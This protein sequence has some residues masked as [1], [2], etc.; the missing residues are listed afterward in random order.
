MDGVEKERLTEKQA[1]MRRVN[2]QISRISQRGRVE[3]EI[4]ELACECAHSCASQ[5]ELAPAEYES[6]RKDPLLFLLAHGHEVPDVDEVVTRA[7]GYVL[8]RKTDGRPAA[9]AKETDTPS[10]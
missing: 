6:A 3:G 10:A 2:E 7:A 1:R 5:V 4:V 8:V 9:V